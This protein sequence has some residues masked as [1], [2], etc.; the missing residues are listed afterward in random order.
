[1]P[2]LG[3]NALPVA[4]VERQSRFEVAGRLPRPHALSI[5]LPDH[6]QMLKNFPIAQF[7]LAD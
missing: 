3:L 6:Y 5:R 4:R 7:L 1:M 2:L